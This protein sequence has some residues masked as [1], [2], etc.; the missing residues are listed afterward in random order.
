M[1]HY[2]LEFAMGLIGI[3]FALCLYRAIKGPT[4]FDRVL[5]FDCMVLHGLGMVMVF[6]MFTSSSAYLD[7]VLVVGLLG[8]IGTVSLA[9]Y[10]E[11]DLVD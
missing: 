10:L 5:A 8:F 3:G 6:S 1:I 11:G 9:A 7:V 4:G 2:W